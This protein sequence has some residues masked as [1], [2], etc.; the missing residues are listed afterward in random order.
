MALVQTSVIAHW[1]G[2]SQSWTAAIIRAVGGGAL[3]ITIF[4]ISHLS[5]IWLMFVD[6][7]SIEIVQYSSG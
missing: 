6:C 1:H 2:E 7:Q 4:I 5:W 3:S